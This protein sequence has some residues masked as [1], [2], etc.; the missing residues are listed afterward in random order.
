MTLRGVLDF[1]HTEDYLGIWGT[2]LVI[3]NVL[4]T[5]VTTFLPIFFQISSL[6]FGFIRHK[7]VALIGEKK[8]TSEDD[9]TSTQ[10][11]QDNFD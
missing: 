9:D 7:Q 3:Y 6:V 10:F 11:D 1:F 4:F 5:T 2:N 8:E